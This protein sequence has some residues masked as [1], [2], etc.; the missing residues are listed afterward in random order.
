[1]TTINNDDDDDKM[2]STTATDNIDSDGSHDNGN[3]IGQ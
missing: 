1:M 2:R 3:G